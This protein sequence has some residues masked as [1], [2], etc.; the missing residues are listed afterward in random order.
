MENYDMTQDPE[1]IALQG[2]A[3]SRGFDAGNHA[4]AYDSEDFDTVWRE[5]EEKQGGFSGEERHAYFA[6]F[7]VG[8]FSSF[9]DSEIADEELLDMLRD[10]AATFA[11]LA[12]HVGIAW[13]D[14]DADDASD[15]A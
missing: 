15:E 13:R 8:F 2:E 3:L 4:S 12:K 6:G 9:E 10:E 1:V 5:E 14:D 11:P 7:I